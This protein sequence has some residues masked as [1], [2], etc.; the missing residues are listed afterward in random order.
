MWRLELHEHKEYGLLHGL[1]CR[2]VGER[3]QLLRLDDLQ[4]VLEPVAAV[5]L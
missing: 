5:L 4:A 1:H 2:L 3:T